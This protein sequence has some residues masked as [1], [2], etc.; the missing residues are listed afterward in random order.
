M[1]ARH[2]HPLT[3]AGSRI[4]GSFNVRDLRRPPI[5]NFVPF[6]TARHVEAR[7]QVG[8]RD[9]RRADHRGRA[10][11]RSNRI[12]FN[13]P[14]RHSSNYRRLGSS[15]LARCVPGVNVSLFTHLD[16]LRADRA[17]FRRFRLVTCTHVIRSNAH[18]CAGFRERVNGR[19][20][21]CKEEKDIASTRLTSNGRVTSPYVAFIRRARSHF[22]TVF[23]LILHR[24]HF[25]TRIAHAN[26][27][28]AIRGIQVTT[29]VVV[30]PSVGGRRIRPIL[31]TGRVSAATAPNG[32]C[33]LLPDRLP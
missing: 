20:R 31:A 26:Q 24:N 23:R 14:G 13:N 17:F 5:P 21:P 10:I 9:N 28:L 1:N 16:L 7:Y 32:I 15:R 27:S 19:V 8:P 11:C 4:G 12:R 6:V 29:R 25:V 3:R 2:A 30:S 18:S 33:R 22:S